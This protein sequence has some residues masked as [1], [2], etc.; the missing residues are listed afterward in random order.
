ML[1]NRESDY[2]LR[3][4]RSLSD[5][6]K[7]AVRDLCQKEDIPQQFCYKILKKLSDAGYV[8]SSRGVGGGCTLTADLKK[9]TLLT[10][11]EALD[12]DRFINACLKPGFVCEWKDKNC[13]VCTYHSYLAN[14][15]RNIDKELSSHSL[16]DMINK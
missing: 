13:N 12:S 3:I 6:E 16:Y 8:S 11:M 1:I 7:H 2:A 10:L 15:Q 14:V 9:V 5:G 4:L